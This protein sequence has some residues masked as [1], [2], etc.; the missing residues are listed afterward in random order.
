MQLGASVVAKPGALLQNLSVDDFRRASGL[1]VYPY[2]VEQTSA[3]DDGLLR[4]WP[5]ASMG[6]E[7]HRGY[8]FQWLALAAT[9]LLFFLV[10][11][12]GKPNG[13]KTT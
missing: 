1:P 3:L 4:D 9:A 6:S 10:T 7:R 2:L 12:F 13:T 8:A 11:S 5:R